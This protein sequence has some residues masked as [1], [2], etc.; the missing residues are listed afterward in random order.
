MMVSFDFSNA[1]CSVS[2]QWNM[3]LGLSSSR[4]G[5]IMS[6]M[7]N[8]YDTWFTKPNHD[9]TSVRFCGVG[10]S[11]MALMY[12]LHGRTMSLVISKPTNS[13]S[14]LAN[15]NFSGFRVIPCLPQVSTSWMLGRGFPLLCQTIGGCHL[16][17]WFCLGWMR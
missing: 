10:K 5:S 1:C 7:L 9:L 11:A 4:K 15:L 13:T 14:S 3:L 12:F 6:A 2:F 8:A 17:I 16:H